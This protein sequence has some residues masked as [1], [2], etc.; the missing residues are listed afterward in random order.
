MESVSTFTDLAAISAQTF[1]ENLT[2]AVTEAET[3]VSTLDLINA[4][5]YTAQIDVKVNDPTGALAIILNGMT[6]GT[7]AGGSNPRDN[8]GRAGG[9]DNRVGNRAGSTPTQD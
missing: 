2:G 8:G 3:I 1:T 4:T 9:V 6:L 7:L 5:P